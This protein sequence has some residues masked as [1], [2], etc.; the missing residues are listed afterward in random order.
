[1]YLSVFVSAFLAAT[2]FPAQSE[3]V[4]AYHLMK[5]HEAAFL[6][7]AIA[8]AGNVGG[9]VIN[10]GLGRLVYR[11]KDK[12]WFPVSADKLGRAEQ[13]Y[14]RYGRYSLLLSWMPFV[15]DPITVAAGVLREPLWSFITLVTIAKGGRYIFTAYLVFNLSSPG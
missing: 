9:A 14:N 1:M 2:L 6:L 12:G 10:W 11:C 13:F 7:I 15:G 8:T 4:L 5:H 3:A